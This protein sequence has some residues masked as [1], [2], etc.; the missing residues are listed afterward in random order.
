MVRQLFLLV[1]TV[2]A[3]RLPVLKAQ[4]GPREEPKAAEADQK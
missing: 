2:P 1:Y 4:T 3:T